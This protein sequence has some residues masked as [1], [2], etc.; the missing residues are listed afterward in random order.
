MIRL[1]RSL[2]ARIIK[3]TLEAAT[4][5]LINNSVRVETEKSNFEIC[6]QGGVEG[7]NQSPVTD[8]E[9]TDRA[10]ITRNHYF[11]VRETYYNDGILNR[12]LRV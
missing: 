9:G 5:S 12:G 7:G 1:Q 6:W 10:S 3:N 4:P 2:D 8:T 11:V